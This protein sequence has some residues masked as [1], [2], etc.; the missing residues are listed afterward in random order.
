[1]RVAKAMAVRLRSA[2]CGSAAFPQDGVDFPVTVGVALPLRR[3]HVLYD[4]SLLRIRRA[5]G[6][7]VPP[8]E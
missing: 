1:M 6:S 8:V 2:G 4:V 7:I 3:S 5:C